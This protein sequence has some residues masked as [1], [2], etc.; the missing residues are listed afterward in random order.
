MRIEQDTYLEE[1][2]LP[3]FSRRHDLIETATSVD[4]DLA[5]ASADTPTPQPSTPH[6]PPERSRT[7]PRPL[8]SSP[9]PT[10]VPAWPSPR[11]R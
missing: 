7:A 3:L 4:R 10:D 1:D 11:E 8:S 6:S 9:R 5:L 2:L